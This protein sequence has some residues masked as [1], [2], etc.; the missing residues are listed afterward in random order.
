M[1]IWGFVRWMALY[2]SLL[3]FLFCALFLLKPHTSQVNCNVAIKDFEVILG[4]SIYD[5]AKG[6]TR[7]GGNEDYIARS[8]VIH[9]QQCFP[10]ALIQA[11]ANGQ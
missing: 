2:I 9:N 11:V 8:I 7:S 1:T 4:A 6:D 5:N 3:V 10:V